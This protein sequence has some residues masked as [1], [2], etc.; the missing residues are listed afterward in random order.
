MAQEVKLNALY[1][2]YKTKGIYMPV[3]LVKNTGDGQDDKPMV[4]YYS[5]SARDL[6]TRP[7]S[8]F[9]ASVE[10][11]EPVKKSDGVVGVGYSV[12]S[13]FE[14]VAESMKQLAGLYAVR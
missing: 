7:L 9:V 3:A 13:R 4:L 8:E 5:F 14:L 12:A 2:H 6:V 10:V 1:Q 11:E